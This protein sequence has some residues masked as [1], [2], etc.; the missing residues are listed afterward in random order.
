M[1]DHNLDSEADM[2][3]RRVLDPDEEI[4]CLKEDIMEY[5]KEHDEAMNGVTPLLNRIDALT[6]RFKE[7]RIAQQ[8]NDNA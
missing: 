3:L 8:E 6:K 4:G 5:L 1:P 7:D 2:L